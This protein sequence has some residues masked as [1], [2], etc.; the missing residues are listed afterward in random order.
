MV[1]AVKARL[2]AFHFSPTFLNAMER[3]RLVPRRYSQ[4]RVTDDVSFSLQ[5][6]FA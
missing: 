2:V 4:K 5:L 1:V 6:P 3:V